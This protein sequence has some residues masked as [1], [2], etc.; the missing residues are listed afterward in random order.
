MELKSPLIFSKKNKQKQIP[1]NI[2]IINYNAHMGD[3]DHEHM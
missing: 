2:I 3:Y 1:V